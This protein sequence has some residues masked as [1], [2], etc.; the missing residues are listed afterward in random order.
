MTADTG[1]V[2]IVV[3]SFHAK[4]AAEI[5]VACGIGNPL[6][7]ISIY[8]LANTFGLEK[9]YALPAFHT[10]TGCDTVSSFA[11]KEKKNKK[12]WDTRM[13]FN[14]VKIAFTVMRDQ[15]RTLNIETTHVYAI[16]R[17]IRYSD[18]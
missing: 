5:W 9:T 12:T 18:V 13:A 3:S 17:M 4:N 7:Y 1:V 2:V 15:A 16:N 10:F 8:E 14:D 6:R 11:D